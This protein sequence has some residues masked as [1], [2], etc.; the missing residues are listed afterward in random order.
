MSTMRRA[1]ASET[2][3]ASGGRIYEDSPTENGRSEVC[4]WLDAELGDAP[5]PDLLIVIGLASGELLSEVDRRSPAT[6]ILALEPDRRVAAAFLGHPASNAWRTSG[7]LKYLAGPEYSGASDAWRLFA[8]PEGF[9]LITR[10][11]LIQGPWVLEAARVVKTFVFGVRA[12]AEACRRFA[13]RYLLNV[14]RNLPSIARGRDVRALAGLFS[15]MPAVIIGAGPSLDATLGDLQDLQSRALLIAA[16]TTLRSLLAAGIAPQLAVGAD[17]GSANARHSLELPDCPSTWLV[18]E[19]A[20]EGSASA[21][22]ADRIFWFRLS[23]H[24]PWRWLNGLDIDVGHI[25][26]WGSVLTAAFRIACLAGCD[27]IIMVGADLAFTGGRP[28]CR[29]RRTSSIGHITPREAHPSMTPGRHRRR[30]A[31]RS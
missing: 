19:S 4:S 21:A 25:D 16:D 24:H 27:P 17:P 30:A 14:V 3:S 22:F 23:N 11:R 15:H 13:P 9:R 7:R 5:L 20:L 1:T 26:M 10:P 18:A 8:R 6:K 12:N 28:Y 29:G 2:S 31:S